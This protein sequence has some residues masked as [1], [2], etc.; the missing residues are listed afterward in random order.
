MRRIG[1]IGVGVDGDFGIVGVD[2]SSLSAMIGS[3][4]MALRAGHQQAKKVVASRVITTMSTTLG[5]L[6]SRP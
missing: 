6:G 3:I 2:H 5:L 1:P 4:F